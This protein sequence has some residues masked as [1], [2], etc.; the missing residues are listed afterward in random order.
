MRAEP[1]LTIE[2]VGHTITIT[3]SDGSECYDVECGC[4]QVD[5]EMSSFGMACDRAFMHA[6]RVGVEAIEE[7][8]R[9]G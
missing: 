9:S 4:S 3:S 2:S 1:M 6:L 5:E 8:K 7:A